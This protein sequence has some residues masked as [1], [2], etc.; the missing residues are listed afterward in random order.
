MAME[1][2]TFFFN[3]GNASSNGPCSIA[4]LFT[5][6]YILIYFG[7]QNISHSNDPYTVMTF[8]V[9]SPN[10]CV[11]VF[12]YYPCQRFEQRLHTF[13]TLFLHV[14]PAS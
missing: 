1:S 12:V 9:R 7:I 4:M 5:G 3:V 11:L 14:G 2:S 6:V 10:M 8:V 13:A